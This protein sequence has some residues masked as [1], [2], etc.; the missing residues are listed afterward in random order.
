MI[1]RSILAALVLTCVAGCSNLSDELI[2]S[3]TGKLDI[4]ALESTTGETADIAR[5][6]A[7]IFEYE[8]ELKADETYSGQFGPFPSSGTWELDDH[9]LILSPKNVSRGMSKQKMKLTVSYAG[10]EI[11]VK[12]PSQ[13]TNLDVIF[14]RDR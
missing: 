11:N 7:K 3:W 8:L 4:K 1:A 2:G 13:E 14:R 9:T 6:I 12:D 10:T 5:G